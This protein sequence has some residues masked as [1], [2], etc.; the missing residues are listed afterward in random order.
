VP[1]ASE[2]SRSFCGAGDRGG[3]QSLREKASSREVLD[4]RSSDNPE[5][6]RMGPSVVGLAQCDNARGEG[7]GG[8]REV[9]E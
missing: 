8:Q 5:Q 4:E 7:G 2:S 9:N 3:A 6:V 1:S